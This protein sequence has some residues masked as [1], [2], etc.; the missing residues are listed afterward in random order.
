[1]LRTGAR[2]T[3]ASPRLT[4]G[5]E[6]LLKKGKIR[7]LPGRYRTGR[8]KGFRIVIGATDDASINA[9]VH[10]EA[11]KLHLLVNIVDNPEL[12]DFYSPAVVRRGE[13]IVAISTS[14]KSPYLSRAIR[15]TLD[16]ALPRKLATLTK[17]L[18]KERNELRGA[19]GAGLRKCLRSLVRGKTLR[20]RMNPGAP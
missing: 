18:G 16:K 2:V 5:L 20:R 1:L 15:Q 9:A 17:M 19:A 3:V 8:L 14:G 13:L 10:K 6:T 7:H 11:K 12:S 4:K